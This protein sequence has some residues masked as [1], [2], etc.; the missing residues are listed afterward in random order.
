MPKKIDHEARKIIILK[1]ALEVFAEEGYKDSNLSLI[2]ERCGLSRP[3][4]YQY[5]KDK[6]QIYYF[7]VKLTTGRMF[8]LYSSVAFNEAYGDE[9]DR[10]IWICNDIIQMAKD[11]EGA[12][13]SLMDVMLQQK[14]ENID[15]S[16]IIEKRTR[17][18]TILFKRLLRLGIQNGTFNSETNIEMVSSHI[19]T[20]LECFC[21]Q[22]AFLGSF[23][24]ES[25][26]DFV[27]TYI[28][29]FKV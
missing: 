22:I 16:E 28:Q 18:L 7:A 3:T 10:I 8:T 27:S 13:R 1:T 19:Y 21:F 15:F 4:L 20:L 5:F 11:N 2:A 29:F 23:N 25:S 9:A 17:K 24:K 26:K 6:E 12:L 14:R